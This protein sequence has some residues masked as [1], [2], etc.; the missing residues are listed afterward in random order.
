MSRKIGSVILTITVVLT[1]FTA[2]ALYLSSPERGSDSLVSQILDEARNRQDSSIVTVSEPLETDLAVRSEEEKMAEKVSSI[3]LEDQNFLNTIGD[4][5]TAYVES[6]LDN[7]EEE[8][9]SSVDEKILGHVESSFN[10]YASSFDSSVD[11]KI[12]SAIVEFEAEYTPSV[13]VKVNNLSSST[14]SRLSSLESEVAQAETMIVDLN[15]KI[16][17]L[18]AEIDDVRAES[19]KADERLESIYSGLVD[20]LLSDEEFVSAIKNMLMERL[21]DVYAS[22]KLAEEIVAS[23]AFKSALESYFA[24]E[25]SVTG[26]I[27]LPEFSTDGDETISDEDYRTLREKFRSGEINKVLEFLGY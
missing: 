24:S 14:G 17:E 15:N 22:D 26:T 20:N 7:I 2:G 6:T 19:E 4:K 9:V 27:P 5:S 1:V 18:E 10:E 23:D 11:E 21:G 25:E 13:D 3:L 12:N 16:F 8:Y